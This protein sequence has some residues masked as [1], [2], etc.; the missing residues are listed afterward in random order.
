MAFGVDGG[1]VANGE[2]A[3]DVRTA[4]G[5]GAFAAGAGPAGGAQLA[6]KSPRIVKRVTI[7]R[8]FSAGNAILLRCM[9]S[10]P[11]P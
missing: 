5:T 2:G 8:D 7:M 6:I 1:I 3:T 4:V 10:H 9:D 11:G